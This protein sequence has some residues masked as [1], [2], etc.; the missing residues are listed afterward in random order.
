GVVDD[1]VERAVGVDRL[2]H[3]VL[4]VVPV[5]D[6][7]VVRHRLAAAVL[8]DLHDLVGRT[9]VA[10]LTLRRAA[11]VVHDD[12]GPLRGELERL[13]AADSSAGAGDDRDL[14]VDQTHLRLPPLGERSPSPL[15]LN[16]AN[17]TFVSP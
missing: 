3:E 13:P 15:C 7:A 6:V 1:D 9:L 17:L 5:A 14:P 12:L 2:A 8:D 10:A 16:A 11:V 4:C